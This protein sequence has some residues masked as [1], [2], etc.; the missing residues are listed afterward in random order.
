MFT[1]ILPVAGQ[2]SRFPNMRPKWLLTM[3]DGR[4]M[5][6]KSIEKIELGLFDRIIIV[7]LKEH[8]T[9]FT[10]EKIVVDSFRE[11]TGFQPELVILDAPTSSQSETIFKA[12]KAADIKGSFFIKD[13]DNVF[14]CHPEPLNAITTIDLNHVE[15][16]DAKNKSYVEVDS[17]GIISNIVEKEVISNYFCCG[18]YSFKSSEAFCSAFKSISSEQEVYISHVIYKMLMNGEEFVRKNASSYVD[19]GTLRE[20]RH[21]CKRHFTLFCDVDGVLLKN[22]SKFAE[23][24]WETKG[25]ESNLNKIKELQRSGSLYLV[26]TS[27]RPESAIEYTVKELSKY[28]V[29]VDRCIFGLPHTRRYLVNDYSPTNPYPSAV[30]IN[31]ERDC[32]M[33]DQ[34]FDD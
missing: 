25:L 28:G 1:L 32:D 18:G 10:S 5:I 26:L 2:S 27:S 3:P 4:L 6:E 15:L 22:G 11:S 21:Y 31:L 23:N 13:C 34:L 12:I 7:C 30:A 19:W 14:H 24:G 8:L 33:L 9:T 20:Y 29:M 17:L 16:I